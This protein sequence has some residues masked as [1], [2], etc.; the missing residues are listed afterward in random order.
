[1][2]VIL[3]AL[4]N[5]AAALPVLRAAAAMA[6][7]LSAECRAVHIRE[8]EH[9]TAAAM[10]DHAGISI[11]ALHG[12]PVDRIAE[13]SADAA[14]GFV[15]VGAR[16]HRAG[17]RP[18]GHV[19]SAVMTQVH[20]PVL[21]VPPDAR[22]PA[23]ERFRHVLV[24]LEGTPAS[25][26][27]VAE[28][29]RALAGA[30]VDIT[31]LHVFRPGTTPRFWDQTAHAHQSWGTEFLAHWCDQPGVALH[32][33]SG[34]VAGAILDVAATEAVDLIALGWSQTMDADRARIVRDIVSRSEVPVLLTP[35][36]R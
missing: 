8:G 31:V 19:A 2:T 34:D 15:V 24:P 11:E 35:V 13:A 10:A 12:N 16:R 21:V 30:G 32:L 7:T 17:R 27:A 28:E 20:K 6:H 25:T 22:L 26:D 4:D 29:M 5:S 14:V 18:S 23:S 36:T 9:D 3:A 1:M 33:R